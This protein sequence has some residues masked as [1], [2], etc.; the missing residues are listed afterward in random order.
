MTVYVTKEEDGTVLI[1][2]RAEG[3][4]MIGDMFH[5]VF[6]GGSAF[7]KTYEEWLALCPGKVDLDPNVGTVP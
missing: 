6:P 1:L 5:E 4:G 3:D 2:A 7:G